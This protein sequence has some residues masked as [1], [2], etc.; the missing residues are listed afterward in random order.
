M[1]LMGSSALSR[2]GTFPLSMAIWKLAPAALAAGNAVV[3]KPSEMTPFSAVRLAQ[4]AEK[5][6][7]PKGLINIVQGDGA[8]T[9]TALTAHP[10]DRQGVVSPARRGRGRPFRKTLL[11][12][13]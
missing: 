11:G 10:G 8:T 9:G 6:G 13:G 1:N 2:P 4:L 7:L 12:L 3:L 5:A